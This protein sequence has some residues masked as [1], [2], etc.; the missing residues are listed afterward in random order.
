[1][2]VCLFRRMLL[3]R[4]HATWLSV[5]LGLFA[6]S[7]LVGCDT[8]SDD[9]PPPETLVEDVALSVANALALHTNGALDVVADLALARVEAI[10]PASAP[11][12]YSA[13]GVTRT[14]RYD[15]PAVTWRVTADG[16]RGSRD[17]DFFADIRRTY[18]LNFLTSDG[19]LI[20]SFDAPNDRATSLQVAVT[21]GT[22]DRDLPGSSSR[23]TN[24]QGSLTVTDLD[25][26]ALTVNGTLTLSGLDRIARD[27][28][29]FAGTNFT[30][31]LTIEDVRGP[32]D[33]RDG[34]AGEATGRITGAYRATY[35]RE[36]GG[37]VTDQQTVE[38]TV[39]IDLES[40]SGLQAL[41]LLFDTQVF[42]ANIETGQ[43]TTLAP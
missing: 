25:A 19:R 8:A 28:N 27:D 32:S 23:L 16:R 15:G 34:W 33:G 20:S 7:L 43:L 42:R 4:L 13:S 6:L 38:R 24:M 10:S 14:Y 21:S 22:S 3:H 1:M 35:S 11:L 39:E 31:V 29:V 12:M 36:V 41:R 37:A 30:L 26:A 40:G 18:T 5:L 17:A 9:E 2:T